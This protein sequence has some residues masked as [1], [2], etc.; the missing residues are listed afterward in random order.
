M[1]SKS[2]AID[3]SSYPERSCAFNKDYLIHPWDIQLSDS[4]VA[5]NKPMHVLMHSTPLSETSTDTSVVQ[6]IGHTILEG[7]SYLVRAFDKL[8]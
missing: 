1:S 3:F 2:L 4:F 7:W 8:F 6:L 5:T